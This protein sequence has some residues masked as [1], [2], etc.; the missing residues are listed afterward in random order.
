VNEVVAAL[1]VR[2]LV[3]VEV[4][5]EVVAAHGVEVEARNRSI[6]RSIDAI[7]HCLSY[8]TSSPPTFVALHTAITW[9]VRSTSCVNAAQRI[10]RLVLI[11][12]AYFITV[13]A[14]EMIH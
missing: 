7:V 2:V 9:R 4:A 12:A 1:L 13:S 5:D 8:H 3:A 10:G 6:D 11:N 14:D